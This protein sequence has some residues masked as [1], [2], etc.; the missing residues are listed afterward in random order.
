[1][2]AC[3]PTAA[4]EG[5]DG[6]AVHVEVIGRTGSLPGI[7]IIG[8]PDASCRE[9]NDRVRAAL[10]S[11]GLKWPPLKLTV[12]LRPTGVRK[13]GPGFDL[14]IALGI[15]VV[16]EQLE[17]AA[18][19]GLGA[20]GELGLDGM[21][22]PVAGMVALAHAVPAGRVIVPDAQGSSVAAVRP[23][24]A[25]SARSLR[26]VFDALS[27]DG[28]PLAIATTSPHDPADDAPVLE[29]AEV[30]G[31]LLA[32]RALE[33]AAA[34]GHHLLM[35]GPAGAGKSMLASRLPALLPDL[36]LSESVSVTKVH[37]VAGSLI[38]ASGLMRRPPF[39]AP[40]HG[41]SA[42]ALI[43]GGSHTIRPG[44]ISLASSG[45]LFLDELGEFPVAVLEALRQPL[46]EGVVRV[47]RA[48]SS[49]VMPAHFQLIGAMNPCPCG[50]FRPGRSCR[51][52]DVA[53]ARYARRLSG[54]LL[55]RFDLRIEV[56][57]PDPHLL[58]GDSP[59]ET[60]ATVARRVLA[61]RDIARSRGVRCNAELPANELDTYAPLTD[62]A[63]SLIEATLLRGVLSGRG[64]RRIRTVARTVA[65][66]AGDE[67]AI[68]ESAIAT[69]LALRATPFSVVGV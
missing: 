55:D 3:I 29:L 19:R 8:M 49:A 11:S 28:P 10:L 56:E 26:E 69:A 64:V 36:D 58:I 63:R 25:L 18:V 27:G 2:F 21:L 16:S 20:L 67:G 37:S 43:G 7:N 53:R 17:P 1:M 24:E 34:G 15:L 41:A 33:I 44:E 52:N 42:A 50:E 65:D 60:T 54:P 40:H 6:L 5:V 9:A 45:V 39:R 4:V 30:R 57:P 68:D 12:N 66:L 31:Q 51:C 38:P 59:H 46:E 61:A 48:H 62:D 35:V 14:A 22:R 23:G 32:R 47:A 13:S